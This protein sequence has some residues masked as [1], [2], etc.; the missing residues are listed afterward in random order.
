MTSRTVAHQAPLSMEFSRQEYWS[1]L[2]FPTP[3]NFPNP[4]IEPTSLVSSA[5]ASSFFSSWATCET[6]NSL[7][8]SSVHSLCCVWL[9]ATPWT[10]ACQASLSITNSQSLLKLISIESMMPSNHFILCRPLLLLPSI[11]SSIRVFS[12]DQFFTSGGQII[13]VSAS[14][15][16]LPMNIQDWYPLGSTGWISLQSRGLSRV[17]F[18]T[19]VQKHQFFGAQLSLQSNS[20]IHTW[21]L[22]K[23]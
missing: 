22:E 1:W 9:F 23:P 2:P 4:R 14:E 3:G 21:L 8:L 16:V 11:F 7:Q 18:D 20:H 19:T 13:G 12:N 5:M 17:F 6:P 15:S 10:V